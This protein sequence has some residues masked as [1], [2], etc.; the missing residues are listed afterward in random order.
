MTSATLKKRSLDLR[1]WKKFCLCYACAFLLI[2][3]F[4]NSDATV[5]YLS[6]ALQLCAK[7]LIPALFPFMV[8][9]SI[10][11]KTNVGEYMFKPLIRPLRFLFGVGTEGSVAICLGWLCGFP[12]GAKCALELYRQGILTNTEY[13]RII[14]VSSTPSPAFLISAVGVSMLS[15]RPIGIFLYSLSVCVNIFLGTAM[16][17][18][19]KSYEKINASASI[20]IKNTKYSFSKAFTR[21][22]CESA[23]DML[24][25]CGFVVFFSAFLGAISQMLSLLE[26]NHTLKAVVAAFFE[27]TSGMS[28]LCSLSSP[29]VLPI[30]AAACGWS[31]LSVHFQTLSICADGDINIGSYFLFHFLR[32]ASSFLIATAFV[33]II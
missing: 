4:K 22:V 33:K 25:I 5:S 30:C 7:R 12:V 21:S 13:K 15:S 19:E 24:R 1:F 10:I 23:E 27:L 17:L 8:V 9:S 14:C 6:S 16:N 28:A 32:A 20:S 31:G 29:I 11:V 2:M 18:L 26:L 3:F